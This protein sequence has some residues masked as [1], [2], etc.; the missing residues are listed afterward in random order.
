[1]NQGFLP[2][3]PYKS[4]GATCGSVLG[5]R[6]K[7]SRVELTFLDE[8][9]SVRP[10]RDIIAMSS[11]PRTLLKASGDGAMHSDSG[12]PRAA[13]PECLYVKCF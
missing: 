5:I 10:E 6:I 3:K 13:C 1:M 12:T 9:V 11:E 8:S 2:P 7:I 4:H